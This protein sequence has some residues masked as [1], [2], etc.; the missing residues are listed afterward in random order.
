[1]I[2]NQFFNQPHNVPHPIQAQIL[3]TT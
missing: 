3:L 1:L 2:D